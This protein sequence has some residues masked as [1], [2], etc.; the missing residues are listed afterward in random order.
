MMTHALLYVYPTVFHTASHSGLDLRVYTAK[1]AYKMA[2]PNDTYTHGLG[3]G[4]YETEED[5]GEGTRSTESSFSSEFNSSID[6]PI[7]STPS[8]SLVRPPHDQNAY[9]RLRSHGTSGPH[10]YYPPHDRHTP[11]AS[12]YEHTDIQI[13]NLMESQHK[14]M[15]MFETFSNRIGDIEKAISSLKSA[16]SANTSPEEKLRVP[17][18]LSVSMMA[19]VYTAL[20]YFIY[21][22]SHT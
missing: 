16:S 11:I 5:D 19:C 21:C 2:L 20:Y 15:F 10:P 3:Y 1:Q 6:R 8:R 14:L 22:L 18:Q 4:L 12:W 13:R 7:S 17:P 9:R